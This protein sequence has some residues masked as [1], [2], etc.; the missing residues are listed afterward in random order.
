[1]IYQC[2][3]V[4]SPTLASLIIAQAIS[5]V[6]RTSPVLRAPL[7][8]KSKRRR[9]AATREPLWSASPRT[10]RKAKFKMCVAVWLLMIGRRRAWAE[11]RSRNIRN[12]D[13]DGKC[14][15]SSLWFVDVISPRRRAETPGLR[16]AASRTLCPRG[17][18]S[19][20]G[21]ACSSPWTPSSAVVRRADVKPK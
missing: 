19:R 21:P 10:P 2:N 3:G 5:S 16:L 11:T 13:D 1:M 9:S 4:N 12:L 8:V 7:A 17:G 20:R 14:F 18:R 6:R 15:H